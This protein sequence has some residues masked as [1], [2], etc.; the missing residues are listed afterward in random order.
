MKVPKLDDQDE[1]HEE[2][3]DRNEIDDDN[4]DGVLKQCQHCHQVG[5]RELQCVDILPLNIYGKT[6]HLA[7][8]CWKRPKIKIKKKVNFG[9]LS[10]WHHTLEAMLL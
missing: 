7:Q 10:M 8:R 6:N 2:K 1:L 9:W 5:H 3:D 4:L